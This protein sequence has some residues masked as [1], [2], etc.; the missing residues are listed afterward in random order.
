[1]TP[2]I[3]RILTRRRGGRDPW[4]VLAELQAVAAQRRRLNRRISDL[5]RRNALGHDVREEIEL[6]WHEL[7]DIN[8]EID[9]L[10]G[11]TL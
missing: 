4:A 6:A 10:Q 2:D 5:E 3:R 9:R 11:E 1:M 8:D 7:G